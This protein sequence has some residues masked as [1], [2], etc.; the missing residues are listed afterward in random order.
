MKTKIAETALVLFD[1]INTN[2][3]KSVIVLLLIFGSKMMAQTNENKALADNLKWSERTALTILNKYP[4]AWQIDGTE[5]PKW[6]YKMSLVLTAFEKLYSKN[7]D[8]KYLNYIKEYADEMIDSLGPD[9]VT[10]DSKKAKDYGIAGGVVVKKINNGVID[11]Q[12]RMSDGFIITKINDKVVKSVE[13]LKAV[14]GSSKDVK[15]EGIYPGY[16]E[17]FEYPLTLDET[18]DDGQ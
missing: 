12:T 3:R 17:I 18:S 5:K 8:E 16:S 9:L 2:Y 14:I 11:N 7:K 10:L 1:V 6:D 13:E 4:K 15:V